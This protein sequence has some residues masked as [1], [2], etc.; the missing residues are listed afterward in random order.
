MSFYQVNLGLFA[1]ANVLLLHHQYVRR[2][3]GRDSR[4]K[5]GEDDRTESQ[6]LLGPPAELPGIARRFQLEYFSVYAFA[7]AADW[8]QVGY[9]IET[10]RH[11]RG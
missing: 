11:A 8:L 9:S 6:Q 5:D 10:N 3:Q 7:V 2:R 1:V 4:S